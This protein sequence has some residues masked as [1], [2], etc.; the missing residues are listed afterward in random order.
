MKILK[1]TQDWCHLC[2]IRQPHL[3]DIWHPNNAE[4]G[5]PNDKYIRICCACG[6]NIVRANEHEKAMIEEY[7]NA[8]YGFCLPEEITPV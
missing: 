7:K 8:K 6:N 1:H 5:G 2:G 3:A 4:H